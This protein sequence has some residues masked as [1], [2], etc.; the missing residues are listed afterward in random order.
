VVILLEHTILGLRT[1]VME[2][3]PDEPIS[4]KKSKYFLSK[5]VR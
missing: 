2:L 3:I 4:V 5:K 1:V